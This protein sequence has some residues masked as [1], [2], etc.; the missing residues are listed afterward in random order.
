MKRAVL[1]AAALLSPSAWAGTDVRDGMEKYK[2][3][4]PTDIRSMPE[5]ERRSAVPIIYI[6]AANAKEILIQS[7]LNTLM[8]HG[9]SDPDGAKRGFQHDLQEPETGNLSVGQLAKL[10]YR[11]ERSNLTEVSFFP[12]SY[13]SYIDESRALVKGTARIPDEKIDFPINYVE[14]QCNSAELHCLLRQFVLKLPDE[15]SWSQSYFISEKP[16]QEYK[17]VRWDEYRI[18]AIPLRPGSCRIPELRLNFAAKEFY[19]IVTNAPEGDCGVAPGVSIPKL[20][21]P[22]ISQ[23]L[24]GD[25]IVS[26]QFEGIRKQNYKFLSSEFRSKIETEFSSNHQSK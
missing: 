17:I 9:L 25:P 20:E 14:I 13:E 24:D 5:G 8:Y 6:Q 11:A 15:N 7:A 23:I 2:N 19:E 18:D 1:F 26:A 4:L 10:F 12:F 22:R 3:W 21:K 16:L